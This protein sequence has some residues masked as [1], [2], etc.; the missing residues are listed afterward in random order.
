MLKTYQG[1]FS[2]NL[3]MC[4]KLLMCTQQLGQGVKTLSSN[5]NWIVSSFAYYLSAKSQKVVQGS[6]CNI[7]HVI[8]YKL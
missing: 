4:I 3:Y 1:M 8:Q 2:C 5:W 7:I 6:P